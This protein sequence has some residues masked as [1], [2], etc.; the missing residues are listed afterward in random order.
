[1]K[2]ADWCHP[3]GIASSIEARMDHPVVPVAHEDAEAYAAWT[4]NGCS[5]RRALVCPGRSL[6]GAIRSYRTARPWPI[7]FRD[8]FPIRTRIYTPGGRGTGAPD[9]GTNH[10]GFRLVRDVKVNRHAEDFLLSECAKA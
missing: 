4:V 2:G 3:E 10:L 8:T 5:R 7:L 6:S 1:M 9:T